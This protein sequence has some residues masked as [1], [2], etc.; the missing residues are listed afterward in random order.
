[1]KKQGL[2]VLLFSAFACVA[3]AAAPVGWRTDGTGRYPDAKP[4][5][6]WSATEKVV[7]KTPLPAWSNASPVIVGDRIFICSEPDTLLCLSATDGKILWQKSNSYEDILSVEELAAVKKAQARSQEL[8]K[9]MHPLQSEL[10]KLGQQIKK[11]PSDEAAKRRSAELKEQLR[12]LEAEQKALAKSGSSLPG[13]QDSNGYSSCTPVSDGRV[14]CMVFGSGVLACYDLEGNRKWARLHEKPKHEW[15]HSCS[16]VIAGGKLVV[17]VLDV[18]GLDLA[19]G[20]EKW[21]VKSQPH[22]GSLATTR[23]AGEDVVLTPDGQLIEAADGKLLAE[24]MASLEYATPFVV[25]GIAYYIEHGGKAVR[26][27]TTTEGKPETL[28]TTKPKDDR[29]YS[30]SLLEGGLLYAVTREKV[31]SVIDGANGEIVYSKTLDLGRGGECYSSITA[32]AGYVF[33]SSDNGTT[34]VLAP[35]R[36]YKEVARNSLDDFRS[37]PVFVGQRMYLRTKKAMYCI[38]E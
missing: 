17:Q 7:W 4:P 24:K 32:A 30:S 19:D 22:W 35:G 21:R 6:N 3:F 36:E 28:W 23:I 37:S 26:L 34:L 11:D 20:S 2:F 31:L 15:G 29:Y 10:R 38:G 8:S 1:M 25:D 13:T 33:L 5:I 27:A 12:P 14:V 16:P 18:V 9:Q